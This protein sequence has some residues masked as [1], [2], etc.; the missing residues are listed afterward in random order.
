MDNVSSPN[1]DPSCRLADERQFVAEGDVHVCLT[2]GDE[3]KRNLSTGRARPGI[4]R[5]LDRLATIGLPV[6]RQRI[7]IDEELVSIQPKDHLGVG[8]CLPVSTT[9]DAHDRMSKAVDD[10]LLKST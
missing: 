6:S 2:S 3:L 1:S 9:V 8:L 5:V 4:Y 10:G 7:P